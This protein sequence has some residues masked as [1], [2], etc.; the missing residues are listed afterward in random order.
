MRSAMMNAEVGDDVFNEDPTVIYL[1]EKIAKLFNKDSA[2]FFPT[3]TMSNLAG[4]MAWCDKRGSEAILGD[5][6]H[7]F[8]YEQGGLSQIGGI[9]PRTINN[10]RDENTHNACG[11]RVLS[12][13]YLEQIRELSNRHG[14]PV[15]MDGARVWNALT[16]LDKLPSDI[17]KQVDSLSVCLSKGL[18]APA[19]SL[20][21]GPNEIITKAKR[22]RKVLG[23]G[24]RQ[25]G[26]LAAAGLRALD[27]FN[28]GILN[29]DHKRA[30]HLAEAINELPAFQIDLNN[31]ETN[32]ILLSI[33]V[34]DM[35]ADVILMLKERGVLA[36]SFGHNVIRLVTHRDIDDD[37]IQRA[38]QA[39]REVSSYLIEKSNSNISNDNSLKENTSIEPSNQQSDVTSPQL[40]LSPSQHVDYHD[41]ITLVIPISDRPHPIEIT[42]P[43][44][45]STSQSPGDVNVYYEEAVIHGMSV[46]DLGFVVLLR[47]VISDRVIS[48]YVTPADP[49]S[50]GLDRDQAETAEAITLLQL[51]QGIDV[52]SYL[53]KNSLNNK[54]A[55]DLESSKQ[56]IILQRVVIDNFTKSKI[57]TDNQLITS[58]S[59]P[60]I[61]PLL[62][63]DKEVEVKSAFEAI[64]L[65]LRHNA[66]IDVQSSLFRDDEISYSLE[67]L[68]SC[69]PLMV[70]TIRSNNDDTNMISSIVN[71]ENESTMSSYSYDTIDIYRTMDRL[72]RQL[73]EAI[74]QRN[75]EKILL[76]SKKLEFY[77]SLDLKKSILVPPNRNQ[78]DSSID[79]ST[80]SK[81]TFTSDTEI[82]TYDINNNNDL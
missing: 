44:H 5:M 25:V 32:I 47:G 82:L 60:T 12:V 73:K 67:E 8:L 71:L 51:L 21:V 30:R 18:G 3:G 15:H 10:N 35:Q 66:I 20:L 13:N 43:S 68:S 27:D 40:I 49:M 9:T 17:G 31:I 28:V 53:P 39:F 63:S 4:S 79:S 37:D 45:K 41:K 29:Y 52:E 34:N 11:G 81:S 61:H 50:D 76:I 14:I 1:E 36:L 33:L 55:I 54:F 72:Q 38:I 64:A 6:S 24:M 58:L 46:S 23:G 16:K 75:D 2:L 19:G 42:Q 7:M 78:T 70:E 22:I 56:Q 59:T 57:F 26:V 80:P 65:A 77:S 48:F 69:F 74:R 62:R